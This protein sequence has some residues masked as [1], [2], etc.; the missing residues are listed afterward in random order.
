MAGK[1]RSSGG[2]DDT[3]SVYCALFVPIWW[4]AVPCH[5]DLAFASVGRA[6]RHAP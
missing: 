4:G 3:R 5:R 2:Q 6:I 1:Q